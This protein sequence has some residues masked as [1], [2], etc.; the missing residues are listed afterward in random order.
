MS[1]LLIL[2]IIFVALSPLITMMPSRR[3]RQLADLRQ[4]AASAG[5]YVKLEKGEDGSQRVFYGCRRQR[6][7]SAAAPVMLAPGEAGWTET[8]GRWPAE[9]LAALEPLPGGVLEVRED[10]EGVG[11]NWDEEG[12]RED[13]EA[14]ARV[15][16]NLLGRSW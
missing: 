1:Y 15:L 4:A 8:A 16:R 3:Q 13:V 9:R 2:L 6:G 11:V 14:I 10:R 5:L 12:T 7:D